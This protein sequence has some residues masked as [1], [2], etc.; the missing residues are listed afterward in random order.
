MDAS[1]RVVFEIDSPDSWFERIAMIDPSRKTFTVIPVPF[2]GDIWL[3]GW[4][5]DGRI[6]AIGERLDS[7]LW[8]Y[9]PSHG[10]QK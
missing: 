3:P 7:T 5:S 4:E 1:G 9:S 8:R 6:A 2:S 10:S